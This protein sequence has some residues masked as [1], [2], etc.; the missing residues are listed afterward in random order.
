MVGGG[1]ICKLVWS[2]ICAGGGTAMPLA[3]IFFLELNKILVMKKKREE[4]RAGTYSE[5]SLGVPLPWAASSAALA[6][7]VS[8]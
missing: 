4:G 3:I 7:L 1:G 2:Q 8:L 6:V 5:G